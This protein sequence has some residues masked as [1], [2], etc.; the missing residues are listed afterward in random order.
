MSITWKADGWSALHFAAHHSRYEFV[1]L[2]IAAGADVNLP[3][4]PLGKTPLSYVGK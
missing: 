1:K 3:Q 2:L 4:S